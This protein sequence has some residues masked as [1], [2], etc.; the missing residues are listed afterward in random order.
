MNSK[1]TNDWTFTD[2][3]PHGDNHPL[4]LLNCHQQL[5]L[6]K[7]V[8]AHSLHHHQMFS[9]TKWSV[10]LSM[11]NYSFSQYLPYTWQL[12]QFANGSGVD[13]RLC[14]ARCS[15]CL[16]DGRPPIARGGI[17]SWQVSA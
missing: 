5:N 14:S 7:L 4:R 9:A 15:F 3:L 8:I 16:C 13:V 1:M 12:F 10:F 17:S 6:T 2:P 11:R